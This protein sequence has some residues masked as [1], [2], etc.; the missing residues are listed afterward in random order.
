[1]GHQIKLNIYRPK[2]MTDV[3]WNKVL[4]IVEDNFVSDDPLENYD[5]MLEIDFYCGYQFLQIQN[6]ASHF[7]E[8][9]GSKMEI[10]VTYLERDPDESMMIG[11]REKHYLNM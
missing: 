5:D 7:D 11:K 8:F 9:I 2:N 6:I 10:R 1:M 3:D 4:T